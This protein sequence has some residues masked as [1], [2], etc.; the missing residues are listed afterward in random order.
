MS[1]CRKVAK[2]VCIMFKD[3]E[4]HGLASS[5]VC[6]RN[7]NKVQQDTI[8]E[9]GTYF[10]C[11]PYKQDSRN[12]QKKAFLFLVYSKRPQRGISIENGQTVFLKKS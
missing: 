3:I 9:Q 6:F 11:K 4:H 2:E 5:P 1:R 8:V 12:S 10:L 7:F